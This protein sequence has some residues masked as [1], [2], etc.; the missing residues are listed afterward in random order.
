MRRGWLKPKE[1][2]ISARFW[3]VQSWC[4]RVAVPVAD[5]SRF[6]VRRQKVS[7]A[8]TVLCSWDNAC[9]VMG[10][11]TET[12]SAVSEK[13]DIIGQVL[14][15]GSGADHVVTCTWYMPVWTAFVDG[16]EASATC[17]ALAWCVLVMSRRA[18]AFWTDCTIGIKRSATPYLSELQ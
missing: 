6:W 15:R 5:R 7:V 8:E 3:I 12:P 13:L 11:S 1:I 10:W 17:V 4:L 2:T 18:A 14:G 16:L 9:S